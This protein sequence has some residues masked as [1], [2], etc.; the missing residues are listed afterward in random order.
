MTAAEDQEWR[1][2]VAVVT[3]VQPLIDAYERGELT[4]EEVTFLRAVVDS[5]WPAVQSVIVNLWAELEPILRR[6]GRWP[7]ADSEQARAEAAYPNHAPSTALDNYRAG[8]EVWDS[9]G[10]P[11]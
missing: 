2:V 9:N 8:H 5:V 10:D 7:V 6:L 11:W 3:S 4:A 1:E